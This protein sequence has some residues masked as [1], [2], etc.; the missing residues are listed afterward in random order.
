MKEDKYPLH[1]HKYISKI[2]SV[3][4]VTSKILKATNIR[5]TVSVGLMVIKLLNHIGKKI[6]ES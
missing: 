2:A 3:T 6:N 5:I 1:D 4:S